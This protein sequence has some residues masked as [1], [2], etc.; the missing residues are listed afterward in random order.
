MKTEALIQ[1]VA[2][3]VVLISA[4]FNQPFAVGVAIAYLLVSAVYKYLYS[5]KAQK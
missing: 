4:F 3:I 2:A 5:P 1:V